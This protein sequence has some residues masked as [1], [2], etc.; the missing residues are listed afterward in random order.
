M[1]ASQTALTAAAARAAHL[2]VDASPRIFAD[3]LAAPLL[4]PLADELLAY[5]RTRGDHP[6]L[7]GARAQTTIRARIAEATLADSGADQ[8]VLLGA[9]LDTYAYRS[10]HAERVHV[11]EVDHPASQQ[12]KRD[13]VAEADLA[14]RG[15]LTHVAVD[16]ETEPAVPALLA[17]GLDLSRPTVVSWLGVTM[18]LT[19]EAIAATLAT[20]GTLA[21]GSR[22]VLD[23]LLPEGM[24]DELGELYVAGVAPVAAQGGEPWRTFLSPEEAGELLRTAGFARVRHADQRSALPARLWQRTDALKPVKLSVIARAAL[25]GPDAAAC[26]S[27]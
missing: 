2:I 23:Y 1:T 21:P 7:A 6:I 18:Y 19:R 20:L 27:W 4:G 25:G 9:G 26:R 14:P 12:W 13:R 5:H 11:F 15:K 16:L 3:T 24:R 8:Y 17:A 10:H 22:L